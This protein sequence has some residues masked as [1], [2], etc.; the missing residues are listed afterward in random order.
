MQIRHRT[1]AGVSTKIGA[2][3]WN[4]DHEII[5]DLPAGPQGPKGD[6]GATGPKGDTGPIGPKGDQGLIGPQGLTGPQGPQGLPGTGGAAGPSLTPEAYGAAGTPFANDTSA[7][8][9]LSAAFK[10]LGGGTIDLKPGAT[11]VLGSQEHSPGNGFRPTE[12]NRYPFDISGCTR[13]VVIRGNGAVIWTEGGLKYGTFGDDGNALST[14]DGYMGPE[15]STPLYAQM[16]ITGC[17]AQVSVYDLDLDGNSAE[18]DLG[19]KWSVDYDWQIACSG[20]QLGH[21]EGPQNTAPILLSNVRSRN[22]CLD[23]LVVFRPGSLASHAHNPITLLNCDFDSNARQGASWVG[24]NGLVAINTKFNNTGRG[25]WKSFPAAGLD[26]EPEAAGCRFGTFIGCEFINNRGFSLLGVGAPSHMSFSNCNF[27]G[28]DAPTLYQA[29]PNWSFDDCSFTGQLLNAWSETSGAGAPT[30]FT[31]CDFLFGTARSPTGQVYAPGDG[32]MFN[33]GGAGANG[34]IFRE[35]LFD[36]EGNTAV[37]LGLTPGAT[38][39]DCEFKQDGTGTA[40]LQYCTWLGTNKFTSAGPIDRYFPVIRGVLITNGSVDDQ[41]INRASVEA[42][43]EAIELT[44][45]PQGEVGPQGIQGPPGQDGA[46]GQDGP[47]GPK[48]DQ[49]IQ[50]PAGSFTSQS[51]ALSSDVQLPTSNTYVNGPS[52]TLAAGT[53]LVMGTAQFQRNA[54]T[55]VHWLA[56]LSDGTTHYTSAQTYSPSV[57]GHTASLAVQ[58]VITLAAQAVIRLQ[59]ATSAGSTTSL[60]KAATPA[61]GSGNNATNILAVKIA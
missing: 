19:G 18:I 6:T 39:A 14:G 15:W 40:Y 17:S 13:P 28:T 2:T 49:G 55:A 23:G 25:R 3:Q 31:R 33:F 16:R 43:I 7:F 12:A 46:P 35:C 4:E 1:V 20:L 9:L 22:Q 61:A 54:T 50:G 51:A 26:I 47:Q 56:R 27:V 53:W 30:K 24:G 52:L 8:V 29:G 45:G 59:G 60:M 38:Y 21:W 36:T 5:G 32:W 11:Y 58:S 48:G 34:V 41:T 37:T 10:I 44:P 57:S 42:S